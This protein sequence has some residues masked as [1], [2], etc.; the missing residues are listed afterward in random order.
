LNSPLVSIIIPVFNGASFIENG[1]ESLLNSSYTNIEILIGDDCSND[2]TP[3]TLERYAQNKKVRVFLFKTR[4]G[5]GSVRNDLIKNASGAFIALQ[6]ADDLSHPE[7]FKKQVDY[8]VRNIS[9]H[10]VGTNASLV[11]SQDKR[12]GK[13]LVPQ[14]PRQIDWL[15][16]KSVVHASLMIRKEAL[17]NFSYHEHLIIGED[18]YLLT[19]LYLSGK[20]IENIPELLYNYHI[21]KSDL[22]TR[23]YR[24]FSKILRAKMAISRLFT[25]PLNIIFISLNFV[26]L[27]LSAIN[28][29]FIKFFIKIA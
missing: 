13:I 3:Q 22:K 11:N 8:L 27:V 16:Q 1:I 6:D 25:F 9:V 10:A 24:H 21:E 14:Y 23:A 7:R 26:L 12:W 19:K 4:R 17:Q 5:A 20:K 29:I 2:Q 15:I 28:G 18:Y